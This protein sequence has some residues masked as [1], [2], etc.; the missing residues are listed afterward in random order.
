MFRLMVFWWQVAFWS[1][2]SHSLTFIYQPFSA[3]EALGQYWMRDLD[4]GSFRKEAYV[5]HIGMSAIVYL[6]EHN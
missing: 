5:A 2:A 4:N 1:I 6:V 3:R